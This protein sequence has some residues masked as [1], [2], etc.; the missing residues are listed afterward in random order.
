LMVVTVAVVTGA[1]NIINRLGLN[2]L[3]ENQALQVPQ[4]IG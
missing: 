2:H 4:V 3:I 1:K